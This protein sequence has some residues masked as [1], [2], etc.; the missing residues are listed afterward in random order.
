M[1]KESEKEKTETGVS[2]YFIDHFVDD[3]HLRLSTLLVQLHPYYFPL[4]YSNTLFLFLD[5][6]KLFLYL[7]I[8]ADSSFPRILNIIS[9]QVFTSETFLIYKIGLVRYLKAL[10]LTVFNSEM[11]FKEVLNDPGQVNVKG[12]LNKFFMN[13]FANFHNFYLKFLKVCAF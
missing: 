10:N 2:Q 7:P 6:T 3:S 5:N 12:H 8:T 13:E 4:L 9:R 1:F 11:F